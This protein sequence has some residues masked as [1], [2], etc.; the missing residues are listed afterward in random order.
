VPVAVTHETLGVRGRHQQPSAGAKETHAVIEET[1]RVGKV[2]E[3]L[4]MADDVE[5][6]F[7][8]LGQDRQVDGADV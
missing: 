1:A 5:S 8:L 7:V 4:E 2:L 6:T 3:H